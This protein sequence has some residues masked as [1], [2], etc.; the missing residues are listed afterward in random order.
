MV[1][2]ELWKVAK[3]AAIPPIKNK[4]TILSTVK[5]L[6]EQMDSLNTQLNSTSMA[7]NGPSSEEDLDKEIH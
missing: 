4:R 3:I 1:V 6:Q 2:S 7:E 5:K